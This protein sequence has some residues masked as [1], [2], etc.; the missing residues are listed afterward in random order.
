M[1]RRFAESECIRSPINSPRLVVATPLC[2]SDP[3]IFYRKP[4]DIQ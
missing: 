2:D 1:G 3:Y 4:S